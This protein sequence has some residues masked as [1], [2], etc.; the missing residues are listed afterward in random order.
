MRGQLQHDYSNDTTT[1]T[2]TT[3]NNNNNTVNLYGI[4]QGTQGHL[5]T[6]NK[7]N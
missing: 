2:T 3:T 1:T 7:Q 6:W 5:T 4:F